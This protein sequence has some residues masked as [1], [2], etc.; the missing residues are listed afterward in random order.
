[1]EAVVIVQGPQATGQVFFKKEG[2]KIHVTGNLSGLAPGKHGFHIHEFGDLTNGCTSTGGHF[3]PLK[4]NHGDISAA[5]RHVGDLGNVVAGQDGTVKLDFHDSLIK[6]EGV[7]S[8]VGR[9]LVI[10]EKADDLGLGGNKDSL[11]NGN[12]GA[13]VGCGIVGLKQPS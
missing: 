4:K 11:L 13:R 2:A 12:A 6:L 7:E 1:M 5:E 3:N 8:I 9:G 10:H